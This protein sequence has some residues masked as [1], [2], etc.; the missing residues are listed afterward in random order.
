MKKELRDKW[1]AALRSGEYAQTRGV[2]HD[3]SGFCCLGVLCVVGGA[4]AKPVGDTD[5]FKYHGSAFFPDTN[6]LEKHYGL[7]DRLA[8]HLA[9]KMNDKGSTFSEIADY[10]EAEVPVDDA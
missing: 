4:V 2:L 1:C 9:N 10:I 6:Q 7:S 5:Q 8:A 3:S